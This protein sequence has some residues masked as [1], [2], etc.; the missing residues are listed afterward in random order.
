MATFLF[1]VSLSA[2]VLLLIAAAVDEVVRVTRR[3]FARASV[4]ETPRSAD[5]RQFHAPARAAARVRAENDRV[6]DHA[7]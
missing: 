3:L 2:S 1:L 4:A 6:T 7:A 5:V